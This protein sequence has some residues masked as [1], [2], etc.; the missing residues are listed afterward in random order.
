[1]NRFNLNFDGRNYFLV[2]HGVVVERLGFLREV[3]GDEVK[4][5]GSQTVLRVLF[6]EF[7]ET[8]EEELTG[9][10]GDAADDGVVEGGG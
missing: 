7:L 10:N 9:C 1:M 6:R 5:V 4:D 2:S 8:S 3:F